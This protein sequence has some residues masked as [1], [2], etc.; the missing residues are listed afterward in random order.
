MGRPNENDP[1]DLDPASERAK[2]D[3]EISKVQTS[4]GAAIPPDS[5]E[6]KQDVERE[7]P[8]STLE[9]DRELPAEDEPRNESV[10]GGEDKPKTER[11]R[12]AA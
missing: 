3:E 5:V 12:D 6:A 11:E 9:P 2:L 1:I 8:G 4:G 7:L 10:E